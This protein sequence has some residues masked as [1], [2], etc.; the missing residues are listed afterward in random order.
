MLT[1]NSFKEHDGFSAVKELTKNRDEVEIFTSGKELPN[2]IAQLQVAGFLHIETYAC[3]NQDSD[4]K[5]IAK[6]DNT[7][8]LK[9]DPD[10]DV[11]E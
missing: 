11:K 2:L 10:W 6:K 7:E 4:W 1:I 9:E 5:V 8:R 3:K